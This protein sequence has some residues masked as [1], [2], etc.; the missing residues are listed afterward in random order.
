M[1]RVAHT[2]SCDEQEVDT[3]ELHMNMQKAQVAA[4]I[5]RDHSMKE[6]TH[7]IMNGES[8]CMFR[9]VSLLLTEPEKEN[10]KTMRLT[11]H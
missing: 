7:V 1:R 3:S 8:N 4:K 11:S 10:V 9:A 6:G 5:I 2:S